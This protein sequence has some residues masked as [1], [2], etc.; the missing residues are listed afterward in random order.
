MSKEKELLEAY[1]EFLDIIDVPVKNH[2]LNFNDKSTLERYRVLRTQIETA[3][4]DYEHS[5]KQ[6]ELYFKQAKELKTIE[7][8]NQKKLKALE[9]I[10]EKGFD[11]YF[12]E[13]A[14]KNYG[15]IIPNETPCD[16]YNRMTKANY[17]EEQFDLL[18]EELL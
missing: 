2:L 5:Q 14:L 10:K 18:L 6:R 11:P 1:N 4:K 9:I 16:Y 7:L 8:D 15:I 17:T 13:Q 12:F 3:L